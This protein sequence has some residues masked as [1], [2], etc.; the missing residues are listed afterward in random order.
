MFGGLHIEKLLLEI[1][2]QLIAGSGL[3]QFLDHAGVSITGAGN[4]A[5]N[6]SQITSARY[7]LQV[8][9][10]AEYKAIKLVCDS[11]ESTQDI[12][13]W[14]DNKASESP[15]FHYWK[16]IFDLQVLILMF[17][18]SER[19]RDFPLYVQVLK[20]AMKYIFAFNHYNYARWLTVHVD[21]L[22]K[23]EEV[24][25]DVYKEFC[26]GNFVV[27]K[28][29][30]PFS[31]IALDQA[32]EQNN[33]TIK[34]VGGAIGLLSQ[35]MD[36]ALR[37]WEVAGPEVC[38]LLSEYERLHNIIPNENKGKHHEDYPEFQK[39]FFCDIQKLF[40]CF[41]EIRN[42]FDE[43]SLVVLDTGEAMSCNI[44]SC[45]ATL[46]EKNEER[47]R[48][49]C[50][51]RIEICDIPIS[52]TVKIY[53]LDL[54][55][56]VTSG[57]E[58]AALRVA[59][60]RNEDK[61]AKS[62]LLCLPH[63][64]DRVKRGFKN[65]VTNFP[66]ALTEGGSMYHSSKSALLKR[67][68]QIPEVILESSQKEGNAMIIDLSVIV[69]AL[70]NRK[71]IKPKTI[72]E[73]CECVSNELNNLSRRSVRMDIVC[74]MYPEGLNLKEL[75]QTE[76]GVGTQ[77]SFDNETE[78]PSDFA[79]NFLRQNENKR[80]FYPYLV[81]KIV[82]G[83]YYKEKTVVATKNESI[84]MNLEGTLADVTMPE[85]SHPEADTRIILHVISCIENGIKDIYI[86]TNDTDVVVLLVAYMPKFLEIGNVVQVVA[87]CGVGFNT[88]YLS[89]NTIAVYVGL[90]RCKEL[91]F[92]HSLSGSDYTSSFFHVGKLKFW[93]AWLTNSDVSETFL[94][95]S[96]RPTL[97][98][99]NEDLEVIESF[100]ISLYDSESDI[101]SCI[102]VARYEIF[103][104]RGSSDIR[105]LP[106][107]RDALIHHIHKAA[108]I[109][110]YLWGMSH[111]PSTTEEP[112]TNWT[113]IVMENKIKC[114]WISYDHHSIT[115]E[116]YKTVF[117]KCGCRKGC[118]KNCKCKKGEQMKCLPTCKCRGKCGLN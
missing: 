59:Q 77:V 44:E 64:E 30:N 12:Q 71:S 1:H 70:S 11:C 62:A 107:T 42:P 80:V 101:S 117:K 7:L 57:S 61:F 103:K 34:G 25:P 24:C 46:L 91:L 31:A 85:S 49:F 43:P 39:T 90:E 79:S 28:T 86:R 17:I 4:V 82:E 75:I 102:D 36:S 47:Y 19:E 58:K 15:M 76:R 22:M 104:Y 45:L 56:N 93:D 69:N 50:E 81:D 13:D 115:Q 2:G 18:R 97:P 8:C 51:R 87:V 10:C 41:V 52:A 112:P 67:F 72:A 73:F 9:L 96:N 54:P 118:K 105:S 83:L 63:R 40:C 65:E 74:D 111:V 106:P 113:W 110:G 89:V 78:F 109:S 14:M 66:S 95:Y 27:R 26:S 20:S 38:R 37:R 114:Q 92:L 48:E 55:G 100:V 21:D 3:A 108:Y 84:I 116:L 98:L 29:T 99:R 6:V 94:L 16:M 5:L 23:L 35:D 68:K 32:H 33:A 88:N 53:K 60:T